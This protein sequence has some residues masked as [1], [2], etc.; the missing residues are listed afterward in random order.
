MKKKWFTLVELLIV[1]GIRWILTTVL[2]RV[3]TT[4]S[5]ISFKIQNNK[6]VYQQVNFLQ[7]YIQNFLNWSKIDYSI[8]QNI[9]QSFEKKPNFQNI[10]NQLDE[11][12][13]QYLQNKIYLTDWFTNIIHL[14]GKNSIWLFQ[15]WNCID[16]TWNKKAFS[17]KIKNQ[18]CRLQIIINWQKDNIT[19]PDN[20]YLSNFIFKILP[21][22]YYKWDVVEF[23]KN[24]QDWQTQWLF[25][26]WTLYIKNRSDNRLSN[27]KQQFQYFY[28]I[29]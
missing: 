26:Y 23:F 1:I 15:T 14:T 21:N 12:T 25:V 3:Y 29:N 16:F 11:Q 5:Q 8:Y 27:S 22:K 6:I 4:I 18:N 24:P 28:E 2:F 13:A 10:D 17:N 7:N 19:N 20:T 9:N